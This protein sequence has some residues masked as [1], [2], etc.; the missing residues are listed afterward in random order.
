MRKVADVSAETEMSEAPVFEKSP[1][2]LD[3]ISPADLDD[4]QR[5]V[6][7]AI[8]G[9]PR[10][11]QAG[12]VPIVDESGR[13]VGPFA[14]MLLTP[15]VG[16]AMQQVGAKI[17]FS[18]AL[19]PRERELGILAVAGELRSDFERLAHEPAALKAGL[20]RAQVNAVLS[21][22]IPGGLT[23]DEAL[24]CRLAHV[25]TAER[26]LPDEDYETGLAA[27][28]KERLA[29]LTWLVGYYSAL[30]L[31]LAVFRPFLPES[32]TAAYDKG[33]RA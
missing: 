28:G 13:L 15:E 10:A 23:G 33:T 8:T 16:N 29:E 18:T 19:T 11:G 4:A 31:S 24:I 21:G 3:L 30:A 17:R 9:G 25:M 1:P 26:N 7:E 20:T 12:T 27:L 6:Y 14:V 32:F 22:Q 2:R 5:T